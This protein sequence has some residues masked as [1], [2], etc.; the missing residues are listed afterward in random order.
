MEDAQWEK[1]R[2]WKEPWR[3]GKEV[4]KVSEELKTRLSQQGYETLADD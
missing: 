2:L 3:E 1:C 4:Y